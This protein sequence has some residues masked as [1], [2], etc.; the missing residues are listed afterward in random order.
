MRLDEIIMTN[1]VVTIGPEEPARTA[2]SRMQRERIRQL[3]VAEGRRLVGALSKRRQ[4]GRDDAE[5]RRSRLVRELMTT[6]VVSA[7]RGTTPRQTANLM[8]GRLIDFLAVV[9]DGCVV[10]IVTASDVLE[11]L[12][13]GSIRA[14]VVAKRRSLRLPPASA[15][16]AARRAQDRMNR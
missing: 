9:E 10:G 16:S 13:R 6:R 1:R 14:A 4:K 11:E 5:S 7:K 2:W 3:I 8:R 12:G 15:R